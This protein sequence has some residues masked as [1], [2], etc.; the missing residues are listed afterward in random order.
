LAITILV[1]VLDVGFLF[2]FYGANSFNMGGEQSKLHQDIRLSA[3]YITKEVRYAAELEIL[4]DASTIP[5]TVTNEDNY[6]YIEDGSVVLKNKEGKQSIPNGLNDGFVF[7]LDF[8][9][10]SSGKAL[11]FNINDEDNKY[12][13]E[14]K[15]LILN[16][17]SVLS[18][19][20]DGE[21]IRYRKIAATSGITSVVLN[22]VSHMQG[23]T[24][25][26]VVTVTTS[27]V[28]DGSS[29]IAEFLDQDNN[30]VSPAVQSDQST[31]SSNEA[32][33]T[34]YAEAGLPAGLYNIKVSLSGVDNPYYA[35]YEIKAQENVPWIDFDGDGVCNVDSG[36]K[37]LTVS[38]LKAPFDTS[39][40]GQGGKL[41]VPAPVGDIVID[42]CWPVNEKLDWKADNGFQIDANVKLSKDGEALITARNGD[43]T[44]NTGVSFTANK[45]TTFTASNGSIFVDGALISNTNDGDISFNA[46][47]NV[48]LPTGTI[49]SNRALFINAGQ[50]V[51]ASAADIASSSYGT[52]KLKAT[53]SINVNNSKISSSN[54]V[55]I[56]S[57]GSINAAGASI[58]SLSYGAIKLDAAGSMN[59][60]NS[61]ISSS[62]AIDLSSRG[63]IIAAGASIDA[64]SNGTIKLDST[65]GSSDI[66]LNGSKIG[67]NS[68]TGKVEI[69]SGGAIYA[70]N[71][72]Y[73]ASMSNG[74]TYLSADDKI[75]ISNITLPAS[76]RLDIEAGG[77]INA[78]SSTM[79]STSWNDVMVHANGDISVKNANITSSK[80]LI[81]NTT[82]KNTIYVE[83]ASWIVPYSSSIPPN[84]SNIAAARPTQQGKK[85]DINPS[86]YIDVK[87]QYR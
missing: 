39:T 73:I 15:V 1:I 72:A 32:E 59:V 40:Y 64:V 44:I 53:G 45:N 11:Y 68:A 78:D 31:I 65:D 67:H 60:E 63:A 77:S 3:E 6:I 18:G 7:V 33:L 49:K 80:D 20:N 85:P 25:S 76:G 8:K 21:A 13:I 19:V 37:K 30:P 24:Q 26:I 2:Y 84:K 79:S 42:Q 52:I 62:S 82:N 29:V 58:G 66:N 57:G 46:G 69:Y 75:E 35:G 54:T 83:N 16:L 38:V 27:N 12:N 41:Y 55:D 86:S 71:G 28:T 81:F 48:S 9:P 36:D 43:I 87:I 51:N 47:D 61:I 22:P 56:A 5:E 50:D 4:A 23:A 10:E 70:N 74:G 34:L 14:S 17:Q